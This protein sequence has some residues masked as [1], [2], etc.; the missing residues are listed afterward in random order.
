[1]TPSLHLMDHKYS[2]PH[3]S[4]PFATFGGRGAHSQQPPVHLLPQ[5]TQSEHWVNLGLQ[6]ALTEST[7][8]AACQAVTGTT[9]RCNC[10]RKLSR[11]QPRD[12]PKETRSTCHD[13][14]LPQRSTLMSC[15]TSAACCWKIAGRLGFMVRVNVPDSTD[16]GERTTCMRKGRHSRKMFIPVLHYMNR[17][18]TL[19]IVTF[20]ISYIFFSCSH[21]MGIVVNICFTHINIYCISCYLNATAKAP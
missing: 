4:H 12:V 20:M 14:F 7:A 2:A 5:F 3:I 6:F 9:P 19:S 15:C 11:G 13:L 1:M 18:T 10:A 8:C 16:K 21:K 17:L